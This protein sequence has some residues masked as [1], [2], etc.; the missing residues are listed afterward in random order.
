MT[1]EAGVVDFLVAVARPLDQTC[2][3]PH[4]STV[5]VPR[6]VASHVTTCHWNSWS[7]SALKRD[8]AHILPSS[9]SLKFDKNVSVDTHQSIRTG[10]ANMGK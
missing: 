1:Y 3:V 5:L 6:S 2:D 9:I 4:T 10:Y 8:V 7:N